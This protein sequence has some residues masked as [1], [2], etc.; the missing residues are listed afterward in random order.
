MN[1]THY[2]VGWQQLSYG[3]PNLLIALAVLF[4]GWII[5]KAIEK[6]VYKA[7]KRTNLD[8]RV[9]ANT[10]NKRFS[11]EK[12]ISKIVYYLLL[13]FVFIFFFNILNLNIIAG[14]LAGMLAT[15]MAAIPSILKAALILLFAWL[16][17]TALSMLIRKAGRTLRV[18]Q[19]M[20]K[21]NLTKNNQDPALLVDKVANI[22]FYLVLLLFLPGVLA[23]LNISGI[24]G[25]FSS[26]L[27]SMLAFLPKLLAAALIVLVG[28]F[29][30]KIV[31]DILTNLLQSIGLEKLVQRFGLAKLFE[32]TS[33]SAIIGNI[34]FVLI[35]IPTV[36]TALDKLNLKGISEPAI[37][38]LTKILTMIPNLIIAVLFVM[39][40]LW[41]GKWVNKFVTELL[42][43]L[44]FT[45]FFNKMGIGNKMSSTSALSLSKIVGYIAQIFVVMLFVVQAL[46]IIKLDFLVRLAT[47]VISYLPSVFAAIIILVVGLY[48]GALVKKLLESILQGGHFRLLS[49][50]AKYAIIAISIFMALDQLG[51]AASIVNAAFI[52][53]LGGLALAFGLAFGLGGKEFASK[54]LAKLDN[55]I[56]HTSIKNPPAN[57]GVVNPNQVQ[58]DPNYF[59]QGPTAQDHSDQPNPFNDPNSPNNEGP[60]QP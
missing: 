54:Y 16:I 42:D 53:I 2:W 7:L 9:F 22:V 36:I 28:W 32:G 39:V 59:N 50:I 56:E 51:V 12:I 5:A 44:G 46:N 34:V 29:I 30:A 33:L 47:A 38:M 15:I 3:L 49:S 6:G 4:I 60:Y 25:P 27:T 48:L 21:L 57:P 17:A 37:Q 19:G 45:S 26:M 58:V 24:S 1:S 8:N 52:L 10:N 35:L 18:H 40:G 11:S 31:R 13:A 43:R 41:I 55:K 14:P 23:A 20:N